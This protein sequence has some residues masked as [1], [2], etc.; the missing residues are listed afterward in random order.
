MAPPRPARPQPVYLNPNVGVFSTE[1]GLVKGEGS[2]A[3]AFVLRPGRYARPLR[4]ATLWKFGE[5][6]IKIQ[7]GAPQRLAALH[8]QGSS[9]GAQGSAWRAAAAC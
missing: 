6:V 9:C 1:G 7:V 2:A 4:F 5:F 3:G 8:P